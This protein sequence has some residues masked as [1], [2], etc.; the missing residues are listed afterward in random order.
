MGDGGDLRS[1]KQAGRKQRKG[2]RGKEKRKKRAMIE[3]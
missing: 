1:N 3:M 2:G